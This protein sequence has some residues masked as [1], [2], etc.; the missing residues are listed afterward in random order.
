MHVD[1]Q[2]IH[3]AEM[4]ESRA[5]ALRSDEDFCRFVRDVTEVT[6]LQDS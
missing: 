1:V 4:P 2:K 5:N 6:G 3:R